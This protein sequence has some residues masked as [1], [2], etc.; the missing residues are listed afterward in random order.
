[1]S[2][3]FNPYYQTFRN[4]FFRSYHEQFNKSCEKL[5]NEVED[6]FCIIDKQGR[7]K[8]IEEGSIK[9]LGY[10]I[11]NKLKYIFF[12]MYGSYV[13][14]MFKGKF[15]HK[16]GETSYVE[17]PIKDANHTYIWVRLNFHPVMINDEM[18]ITVIAKDVTKKRAL[19]EQFGENNLWSKSIIENVKLGIILE[20]TDRKIVSV[21][22][23]LIEIFKIDANPEDFIGIHCAAAAEAVKDLFVTPDAFMQSTLKTI[24]EKIEIIDEIFELKNGQIIERSFFQFTSNLGENACF[25]LYNDVTEN[26]RLLNLLTEKEARYRGILENTQL[27]VLDAD[28]AGNITY[29]SP[30]FC[31]MGGYEEAELLGTNVRDG[32]LYDDDSLDYFAN[33]MKNYHPKTFPKNAHEFQ[34][35]TKNESKVWVLVSMSPSVDCSGKIISYTGFYYDITERKALEQSLRSANRV[36]KKAEES[37]RL[38][39][40][41][42]THELKTP[43]NAILGMGDLLKLTPL[44]RE[45]REYV[46]I[47]DTSTKFLQKLVSDILDISKIESGLIELRKEPFNLMSL[48]LEIVHSFDFSLAKNNIQFNIKFDFRPNLEILGDKVILQQIISNLLS[49]AEKFTQKGSITL[50]VEQIEENA[51]EIKL[52][53]KVKDTGIG[54]DENVKDLIFEKFIQLPS[55]NQHKSPGTGLGL[56]IVKQLLAFKGSTIEVHSIVGKGSAFSF[57]LFFRKNT[58]ET[59]IIT[60]NKKRNFTNPFNNVNILVVEDNELN[61]QYLSKVLSK[62]STNFDIATSGEDALAKFSQKKYNLVLLDLQLPGINGFETALQLRVLFPDQLFTIIAMTAVVTSNIEREIIKYGM[63]DIIKKPFSIDDL[64]D[65]IASYFLVDTNSSTQEI[66]FYNSLDTD[67]LHQFYGNDYGF[68]LSVFETFS[69]NYLGDFKEIIANANK[70]PQYEIDFRLHSIKPSFKMIGMT[71]I[72]HKIEEYLTREDKEG[73]KLKDIF[74]EAK[75]STIEMILN[76]QIDILK[77]ITEWSIFTPTE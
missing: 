1:M 31:K 57:D 54:F 24:Q 25:W 30:I 41:S 26:R 50:L 55:I 37:E 17:F 56:N 46:E 22:K 65:K 6:L 3:S 12:E 60:T 2:I 23:K 77:K 35:I 18:L 21:N 75:V 62:W 59:R 52:H 63:N 5:E 9:V 40:A 10:T 19:L 28:A 74:T 15:D 13:K 67:F 38:F 16:N 49:N 20:D 72:E 36:S 48:L 14:K 70:I 58:F 73:I 8:F 43:I 44:N 64:Y 32:L 47:L 66:P 29:V 4:F 33:L 45:Q 39:V 27:G 69:N 68:A 51:D 11:N 61:I 76:K 7:T 53:F 34:L 71:D 42:M